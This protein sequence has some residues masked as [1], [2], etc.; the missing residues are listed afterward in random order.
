FF[1]NFLLKSVQPERRK[2]IKTFSIWE[3]AQSRISVGILQRF[4]QHQEELKVKIDAS[5]TLIKE[6]AVI[7]SPANRNIVYKLD[8][9]FDII[10]SH[11]Q[12][13]LAQAKE[14][15]KMQN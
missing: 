13:H 5:E 15:L 14:I 7:S 1:G 4:I 9:A 12:R 10:V 2:K 11:E 3:P 8:T 6:E